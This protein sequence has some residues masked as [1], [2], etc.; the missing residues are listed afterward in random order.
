[1]IQ[2]ATKTSI[3]LG[4]GFWSHI[5]WDDKGEKGV[6]QQGRIWVNKN[7]PE[8]KTVWINAACDGYGKIINLM[9]FLN[10]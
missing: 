4:G 2:K 7:N 5:S 9:N 6:D 3:H 1:M 8:C 10:K